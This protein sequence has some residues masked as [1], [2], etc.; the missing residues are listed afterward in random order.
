MKTWPPAVIGESHQCRRKDS[1]GNAL[2]DFGMAKYAEE[3]FQFETLG[4]DNSRVFN[5]AERTAWGASTNHLE[6][7]PKSELRY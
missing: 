4:T 1:C 3:K 6:G 2:L 5:K 7:V